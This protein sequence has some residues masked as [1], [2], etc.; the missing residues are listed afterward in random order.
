MQKVSLTFSSMPQTRLVCTN[1]L[2]GRT[3]EQTKLAAYLVELYFKTA[4]KQV[5]FQLNC[6]VRN[7]ALP[8][9]FCFLCPDGIQALYLLALIQRISVTLTAHHT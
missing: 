9:A 6:V 7:N 3:D 1:I 8:C 2:S 4:I 5:S